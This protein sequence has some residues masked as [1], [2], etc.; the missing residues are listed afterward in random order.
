MLGVV[1]FIHI[2]VSMLL[3]LV[4]L[5]QSSKGGGLA[6]AFGGGGGMSAAFGGRGA[7]TFLSRVTT[8]L[9]VTFMLSC[10]AQVFISKNQSVGQSLLQQELSRTGGSGPPNRGS[11]PCPGTN[12]LNCILGTLALGFIL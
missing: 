11:N 6:G 8:I 7:G 12:N 3:V 2:M 4:V 1:I 10:L 9:A 5:M